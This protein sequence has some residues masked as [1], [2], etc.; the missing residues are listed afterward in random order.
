MAKE[1]LT[2]WDAP[3]QP[4]RPPLQTIDPAAARFMRGL[5]P[6]ASSPVASTPREPD[7]KWYQFRKKYKGKSL[8]QTP[9]TYLWYLALIGFNVFMMFSDGDLDGADIMNG[10]SIGFV[11]GVM[12]FTWMQRQSKAF[13]DRMKELDIDIATSQMRIEMDMEMERVQ[14]EA[15]IMVDQARRDAQEYVRR[16]LGQR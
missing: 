16:A 4:D 1:K 2:P 11:A 15:R 3:Y 7:P 5:N 12:L 10:G 6:L 9:L 14:R 8:W 13:D